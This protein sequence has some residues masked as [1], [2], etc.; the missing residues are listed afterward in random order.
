MPIVAVS[1]TTGTTMTSRM[2]AHIMKTD[3]RQVGMTTSDG[4]YIKTTRIASGDQSGPESVQKILRN[5]GVEFAVCETGREGILRAGLGFERCDVAVVT[6]VSCENLSPISTATA[7][8]LARIDA[9]VS[10]SVAPDGAS[11][12]NADDAWTVAMAETAGGEVIF[13]SRDEESTVVRDH[14]RQGGT[15][16]V[17]REA[18]GGLMLTLL[19]GSTETRL[20]LTQEILVSASAERTD[21]DVHSAMAAAAAAFAQGVPASV[22]ANALRTLSLTGA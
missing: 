22:I 10:R 9:V 17:L 1:G 5:P 16:V 11:V 6:N 4:M 2:I 15:A 21:I 20:L 14:L 8:E 7:E 13:F 12:L 18:P 3:G 19:E